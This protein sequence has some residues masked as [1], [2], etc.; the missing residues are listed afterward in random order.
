M[1]QKGVERSLVSNFFFLDEGVDVQTGYGSTNSESP[2]PRFLL[3][4]ALSTSPS[5]PLCLSLCLSLWTLK[6]GN[7]HRESPKGSY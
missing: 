1:S 5:L 3:Q 2:S 6:Q 7:W 4:C